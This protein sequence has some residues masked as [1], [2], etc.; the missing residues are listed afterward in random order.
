MTP[1][2]IVIVVRVSHFLRWHEQLR[3]SLSRRWPGAEVAYRFEPQE[4]PQPL[5][6]S[7]L[8]TLERMLLRRGKTTLCDRLDPAAAPATL[9]V[10]ADIVVDLIG[11]ASPTSGK[12]VLKPLYDGHESEQAAVAAAFSGEAPFLAIEDA[13]TG[14]SV[15]QGLPSFEAADG[16]TGAL[17]AIYSRIATLIE[18]AIAAPGHNFE[19]S[20]APTRRAPPTPM[21]FLTGNLAFQCIRA[22]YHLCCHSPHWRVGWRFVDGPGVLETGALSGVPW[23][24]MQD[25]EM[26]FAA[27]PFPIEWRGRMGVFY[28][29]LDY[30]TNIGEICFQ[31]F[32]ACGPTGEPV[33]ALKEP[34]HLSYP[35]LI[36][37]DGELYM[38]PEASAS[39][40]LT[41][42][43]CVAF[44][45][46]WEPIAR[47][48]EGIEAADATVFR[49]GDSF[50]MTSVV[51]EGFGGYSD[52]LAIHRATSIFGPWEPHAL[53]PVLVDSRYARPAGAVVAQG[54]ALYRPVQDCSRGYGKGLAI[55]RIDQLDEAVFEQTLV[56]HMSPGPDWPGGRLHTLNRSGRLECI[57]GAILT[58]KPLALRRYLHEKTDGR[59]LAG[60]RQSRDAETLAAG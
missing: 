5:A 23:R 35:S 16:L 48:L 32:D 4:D 42:Y 29:R 19:G 14:R 36:E 18:K 34:W 37:H 41:L 17:E 25:R 3:Q 30:R 44:P 33:P 20:P 59:R 40:G 47:L 28:E 60:L 27:D 13:A 11:D 6:V 31:A 45:N 26:S 7:Q 55:M 22:I 52:T 10:A 12:R 24:A 9:D 15:A 54:G 39:S 8:L 46:R 58:P 51:R 56:S 43:R 49:H 53:S 2:R 57:D 1:S 21:V 50:W 38:L